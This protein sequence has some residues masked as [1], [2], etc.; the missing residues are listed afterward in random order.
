M[1]ILRPYAVTNDNLT[2]NIAEAGTYPEYSVAAAYGVGDTVINAAGAN[3]THHVYQSVAAANLGNALSDPSK[4]LDLGPTNRFAMFD[5]VNGTATTGASIDAT[6]AVT[7]RADGVALFGLN[8][9]AVRVSMTTTGAAARTNLLIS[10]E[11]FDIAPWTKNN[12]LAFRSNG[13]IAPD[14]TVTADT[15]AHTASSPSVGVFQTITVPAGS[16]MSIYAKEGTGRYLAITHSTSGGSWGQFDLRAGSVV[17]SGNGTASIEDVGG[18]WYRCKLGNV[19]AAGAYFIAQVL[20][21]TSSS[22][23]WVT[24]TAAADE[25]IHIWG[26]QLETGSNP[27]GYIQTTSAAVTTTTLGVYEY[28]YNL[29][30][31]SGI[32]NWYDY[33][34]EEIVYDSDL[35]V[36]DLP[37]YTNPKL[38]V[39]IVS[40]TGTVS[41]GTMALGQ[42]RELGGTTYGARS[43]IQDYSRKEADGFGNYTLVERSFA[44]RSTYKVVCDNEQVDEI[45]NLLASVRA[46]PTIWIGTEDYAM[47]WVFGWPRDWAVEVAYPT[48]SFLTIEIEGLI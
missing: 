28:T 35:V 48:K 9:Q 19:S 31:D 4:W 38:R 16:S 46:T 36:T 45:F 43:G 14:Q 39:Q 15:I 6:V 5:N 10:S 34:S 20:T 25:S 23:P 8:A 24:Q 7:G 32:T 17:S 44:K 41:C 2:S 30:S 37:L 11:Q 21:T 1:K 22:N 29:Q 13:I 18:G 27:T 3:P 26:A 33:F 12:C 42:Q 47:T 40:A